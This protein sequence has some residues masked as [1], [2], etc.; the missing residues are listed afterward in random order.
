[1]PFDNRHIASVTM[2]DMLSVS[3]YYSFTRRMTGLCTIRYFG[4]N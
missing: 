3:H 1:M 2:A 4:Q